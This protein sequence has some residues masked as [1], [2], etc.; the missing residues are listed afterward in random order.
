MRPLRRLLITTVVLAFSV[1]ALGANVAAANEG[2]P[3]PDV[4]PYDP[5]LPGSHLPPPPPPLLC[6]LK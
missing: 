1:L 2:G 5:G 4:V 3:G 6:L